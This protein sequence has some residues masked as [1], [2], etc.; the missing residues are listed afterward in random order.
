MTALALKRGDFNRRMKLS[1]GGLLQLKWWIKFLEHEQSPRLLAPMLRNYNA[2]MLRNYNAPML[3]NYNVP[4][5]HN[6]NAPM[7]R[8]SIS[9][10]I[11]FPSALGTHFL[12]LL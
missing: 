11:G 3:R 12:M 6:Y 7:L 4:M 8:N 10:K 1:E 5:L 2:P 9:I